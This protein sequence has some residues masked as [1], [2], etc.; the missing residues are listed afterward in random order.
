MTAQDVI[1]DAVGFGA[2]AT[3]GNAGTTYHITSLA[4]SG[5]GSF[6]SRHRFLSLKQILLQFEC[7]FSYACNPGHT[8][9][10]FSRKMTVSGSDML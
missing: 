8:E 5:T 1:P 7:A 4:G 3:G 6:V 9:I 10:I 2:I